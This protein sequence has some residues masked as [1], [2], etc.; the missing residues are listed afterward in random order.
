M[1]EPIKPGYLKKS[2]KWRKLSLMDIVTLLH[3]VHEGA[4]TADV[5]FEDAMES[6]GSL[7]QKLDKQKVW[8]D[9]SVLESAL[10][11]CNLM[12]DKKRFWDT[13]GRS[14]DDFVK[15]VLEGGSFDKF[16]NLT[17]REEDK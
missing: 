7:T 17:E 13:R 16:F 14:F 10:W 8:V 6:L 9:P 3:N 1:S 2:E 5:G 15:R 11:S 4:R 12:N